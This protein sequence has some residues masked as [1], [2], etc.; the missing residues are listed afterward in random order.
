MHADCPTVESSHQLGPVGR[1][2]GHAGMKKLFAA[3]GIGVIPLAAGADYLVQEIR[4]EKRD[5]EVVVLASP[6]GPAVPEYRQRLSDRLRARDR[7]GGS[8][9]PGV[10]HTRRPT[11]LP[12]ALMLEWLAHAALHQN[13][14]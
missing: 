13:P 14:G 5:A 11:V 9:H 7:R 12:M 10:A 8:C 3:E 4:G 6:I 2:H 1:R